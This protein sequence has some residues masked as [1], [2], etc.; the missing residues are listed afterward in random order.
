[1]PPTSFMMV[2]VPAA[3]LAMPAGSADMQ[4]GN[5]GGSQ[6][7]GC[8]TDPFAHNPFLRGKFKIVK[9]APCIGEVPSG[10]Q[11]SNGRPEV[12]SGCI[13]D[14]FAH[15]PF[16][17]GK[18]KIVKAAPCIGEVPSG[19]QESNGRPEVGSG[20]IADPF[21]HNP[22]LR[23]KF[24]IVKAAPCISE[25]PSGSQESNDRPEVGSGCIP[26]PFAHN[27][28]LRGKFNLCSSPGSNGCSNGPVSPGG[29]AGQAGQSPKRPTTPS[30]PEPQQSQE[31]KRL[32]NPPECGTISQPK[33]RIVGG[34]PTSIMQMPWMARLG[35]KELGT[36]AGNLT[37]KC[38]GSLINHRYVLTAA[39]CVFDITTRRIL[40]PVAV[41]LGVW[42]VKSE[43]DCET[44]SDKRVCSPPTV[45][46]SIARVLIH[47]QY[48][49]RSRTSDIALVRLRSPVTFTG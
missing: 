12:G 15:N 41:L 42:D 22:F 17:R 6:S 37:Y 26:D 28:F 35:Y 25:A 30:P 47:P 43:S 44:I 10:S 45:L 14:P 27:P 48:D 11:E 18:F 16:L 20:C 32:I 2:L 3:M 34:K 24:K 4:N 39:H 40:Y 36:F 1:M 23:G 9:A 31:H 29:Q 8:I 21:A 19:S 38:G 5:V 7:S 13:A 33:D 49:H 46:K